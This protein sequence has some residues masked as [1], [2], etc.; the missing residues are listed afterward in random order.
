MA[1]CNPND[2]YWIAVY[3]PINVADIGTKNEFYFKF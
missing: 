2:P 1:D 3:A